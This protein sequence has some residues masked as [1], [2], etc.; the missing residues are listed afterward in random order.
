[1]YLDEKG[2][3]EIDCSKNI[4]IPTTYNYIRHPTIQ[5]TLF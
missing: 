2:I 1:M 5:T 4:E 3:R